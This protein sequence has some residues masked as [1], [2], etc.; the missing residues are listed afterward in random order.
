ML[1][2]WH[3]K[4]HINLKMDLIHVNYHSYIAYILYSQLS[5]INTRQ[6]DR[7]NMRVMGQFQNQ[8]HMHNIH[9]DRENNLYINYLDILDRHQDIYHIQPYTDHNY[10]HF[11]YITHN[12]HL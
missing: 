2:I 4:V 5:I 8:A 12:D 6:V 1:Y 7:V 3:H 9:K 10:L 11:Y